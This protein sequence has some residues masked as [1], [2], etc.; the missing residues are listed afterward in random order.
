MTCGLVHAA[1]LCRQIAHNAVAHDAS[2]RQGRTKAGRSAPGR[3]SPGP[4]EPERGA[5]AAPARRGDLLDWYDRHAR[6]LPW[7]AAAGAP[8]DPYRVWL[9]EIMLQQTTVTA[10]APYFARFLARWPRRAGAGRG[11][12]SMMCSSPGPGSAT[13]RA[14]A[15]C[16]PAPARWWSA[17]AAAFPSTE[18]EL[19]EL[20]GIGPYTAAAIAA[21]AFGARAAAVDGN[22]ERVVARLFALE[23]ELP[24]AKPQIRKLAAGLV[25]AP[26][27]RRLRPG[28]DGSGRHH[29]HPQAAGLR[30]LSVDEGLPGVP[31]RR[32]RELSA[33]GAQARAAGC[34]AAPPSW[35]CAPTA[36]CSCAR[37][38]PRGCSAA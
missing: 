26:A 1:C 23:Q 14:P 28:H 32:S 15:I 3:E 38:R 22:V 33:P 25:P 19:A 31:P 30:D 35:R 9:S 4:G 37:V 34:G 6:V 20:P 24:A 10:V 16:T 18:A 2:R 12:R 27:V 17:T 7:R 11:R 36:A 21:I 13:T 29:L 5:G 8:A